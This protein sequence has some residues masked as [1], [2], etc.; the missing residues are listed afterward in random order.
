MPHSKPDHTT[1]NPAAPSGIPPG[2]VVAHTLSDFAK[3]DRS[4]VYPRGAAPTVDHVTQVAP[5][6]FNFNLRHRGS[7]YDGDR[8]LQWNYKGHPKSRAEV[9]LKQPKIQVGETWDFGTTVQLDPDFV[10][11]ES[12]CNLTQPVFSVGF[13]TLVDQRG[14]TI[15]GEFYYNADPDAIGRDLKLV[16]RVTFKRGTWASFVFRIKFAKHGSIS[17]SMNGDAFAGLDG[18]DTSRA[19]EPTYKIGLYGTG[20]KDVHGKQLKDSQLQHK[21]IYMAKIC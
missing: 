2:A 7:W 13:F 17:M 11:S 21:H 19:K 10:P 3:I 15:T 16:R 9:K 18:V 14:D 12:Y 20:L 1:G 8:D 5:G 6:T 4:L